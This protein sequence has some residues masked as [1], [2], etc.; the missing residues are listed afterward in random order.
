MS[1]GESEPLAGGSVPS[2]S[3]GEAGRP[4]RDPFRSLL[5]LARHGQVVRYRGGSEP[6]YLVNHPD[7]IKRV[8]VDNHTNYTK[9]TLVNTIFKVAVADGLLTS[10]GEQWRRQ[11]RLMQPAFQRERLAET[12]RHYVN[13]SIAHQ[14]AFP[15]GRITTG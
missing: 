14:A 5:N 7:V 12:Y 9:G 13:N 1:I 6:A 4:P 11:R 10:E 8:L 2:P 3:E 15:D